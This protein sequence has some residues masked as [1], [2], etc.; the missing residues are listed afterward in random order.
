M[1][2]KAKSGFYGESPTGMQILIQRCESALNYNYNHRNMRIKSAQVKEHYN[3]P[4]TSNGIIQNRPHEI[5]KMF[6]ETPKPV[7]QTPQTAKAKSVSELRRRH[8][9]DH[10][11]RELE[12]R[13]YS[14]TSTN[15]T[16]TNTTPSPRRQRVLTSKESIKLE[17]E[18]E[19]E[20]NALEDPEDNESFAMSKD[21]EISRPQ[22]SV[23]SKH[24]SESNK[25]KKSPSELAKSHLASESVE[26]LSKCSTKSSLKGTKISEN[27]ENEDDEIKKETQ[28]HTEIDFQ[29]LNPF[30]LKVLTEMN[31][32]SDLYHSTREDMVKK[33][34]LAPLHHKH[35]LQRHDS[36]FR[37][38][39]VSIDLSLLEFNQR[40][41]SASDRKR[42]RAS[43]FINW[44]KRS[45]LLVMRNFFNFYFMENFVEIALLFY[46]NLEFFLA[47]CLMYGLK[48]CSKKSLKILKLVGTAGEMQIA[49]FSKLVSRF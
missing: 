1:Y 26:S 35:H 39:S 42:S 24:S 25:E 10:I 9:L 22:S 21:E 11:E 12:S 38:S 2:A 20:K 37:R 41:S 45:K 46:I 3:R 40:E 4:V 31:D 19:E 44:S 27:E 30:A 43:R 6:L 47:G 33:P 18:S 15:V 17:P 7:S 8:Y 23:H 49:S 34:L 36:K 48:K 28:T 5:R 13:I 29:S 32:P 14:R 16:T